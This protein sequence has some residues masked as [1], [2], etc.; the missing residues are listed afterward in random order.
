[1]FIC[2]VSVSHIIIKGL[3]LLGHSASASVSNILLIQKKICIEDFMRSTVS[4]NLFFFIYLNQI[5]GH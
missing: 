1:M 4:W 3:M 2:I 5:T